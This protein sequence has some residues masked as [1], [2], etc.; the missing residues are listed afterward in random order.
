MHAEIQPLLTTNNLTARV[1]KVHFGASSPC[2]L[3]V[4]EPPL[5]SPFLTS[6]LLVRVP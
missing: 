5:A 6:S 2:S 3:S 1:A 4:P